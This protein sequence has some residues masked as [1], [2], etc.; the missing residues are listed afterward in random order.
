[1]NY[2]TEILAFN[3]LM[4]INPLSTGQ[5]ALWYA[6]M[7]INN[8]R[9]WAEWFTVPMSTLELRTGLSRKAIYNARNV[10]KQRGMLEF[11]ENGTSKA[12]RYKLNSLSKNTYLTTQDTT[13]PTTYPATQDTT[14][15]TTPLNKQNKNKTKQKKDISNDI[16][17]ENDPFSEYAGEDTEMLK[18]L[19]DYEAMR[20]EKKD[21]LSSRAKEL[22]LSKLEK[23]ADTRAEKIEVLEQSVLCGWKGL[24][25]LKGGVKGG[26]GKD[27]G[28]NPAAFTTRFGNYL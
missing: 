9:S 2:I 18:A 17:K 7:Y 24:F 5:I 10:L 13:Y 4:E 28:G 21:P 1:M 16:S 26:A 15:L 25:E 8:K 22:A 14:H 12:S 3:D 23:L 11:S 20:K 27:T 19:R 6:L